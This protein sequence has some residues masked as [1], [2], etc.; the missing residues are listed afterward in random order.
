MDR[1]VVPNNSKKKKA[2]RYYR[3]TLYWATLANS[4][5]FNVGFVTTDVAVGAS[6]A[7]GYAQSAHRDWYS[8]VP[9]NCSAKDIAQQMLFGE[10][11]SQ[12]RVMLGGGSL[13]FLPE[14]PKAESERMFPGDDLT[15]NQPGVR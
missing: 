4:S 15:I 9:P 5:T 3:N 10:V 12:M 14:T 8:S 13:Y 2:C 7:A 11:G 6:P 1:Y